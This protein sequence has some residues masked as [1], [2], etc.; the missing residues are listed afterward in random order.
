MW[1]GVVRIGPFSA[2]GGFW[3]EIIIYF[4]E[5]C[6]ILALFSNFVPYFV[7]GKSRFGLIVAVCSRFRAIYR[8][9]SYTIH[10]TGVGGEG[11]IGW[12]TLV[13][14]LVPSF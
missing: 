13:F 6:I 2:H 11:G 3:L 5:I 1:L 8:D 12:N 7:L 10:S 4:F 9:F 14:S